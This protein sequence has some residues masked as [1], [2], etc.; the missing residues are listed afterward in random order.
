[1]YSPTQLGVLLKPI[2]SGYVSQ[3]GIPLKFSYKWT[4]DIDHR[5]YRTMDFIPYNKEYPI[6]GRVFNLFEGFNPDIYG[7]EMDDATIKKKIAPYLDCQENYVV[8]MTNMLC[9]STGLLRR[10][11]KILIIKSRYA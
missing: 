10:F 9:I 11:S 1:M 5:L 2:L 7:K 8:A 6:D 3:Q 4:N